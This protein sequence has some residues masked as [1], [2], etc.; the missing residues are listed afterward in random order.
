MVEGIRK[1]EKSL[2]SQKKIYTLEKPIERWAKRS[3]VA[4]NN[5]KKGE[6]FSESNIWSKRPGTGIPSRFFYKLIGKIAKKNI[7]KN[8]LIKKNHFS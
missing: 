8:S 5:I 3:I 2:G 7:K 6:K 4:I 1:I